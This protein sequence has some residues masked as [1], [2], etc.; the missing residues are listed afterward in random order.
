MNIQLNLYRLQKSFVAFFIARKK[1]ARCFLL[2]GWNVYIHQTGKTKRER[3]SVK[4]VENEK[5]E[6]HKREREEES[7]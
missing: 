5:E 7:A 3:K 1:S 2:R 6:I 4:N